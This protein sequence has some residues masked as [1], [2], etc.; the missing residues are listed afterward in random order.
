MKAQIWNPRPTMRIVQT[1]LGMTW[2]ILVASDSEFF[3]TT[4]NPAFFHGAY[5]LGP[6][7]AELRFP[8]SPGLA[9]HGTWQP[10]PEGDLSFQAV[11]RDWVREFNRSLASEASTLVFTHEKA[12]WVNTLLHRRKPYLFRLVWTTP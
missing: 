12:L 2:R 5:G 9:L 11:P 1:I 7:N 10:D 6:A 4:D 3:L 8:L